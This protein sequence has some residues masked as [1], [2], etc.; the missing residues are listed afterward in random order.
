MECFL[1]FQQ[2]FFIDVNSALRGVR[3]THQTVLI[4]LKKFQ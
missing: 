3:I 1:D 2:V 4:L